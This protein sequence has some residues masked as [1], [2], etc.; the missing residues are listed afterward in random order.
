MDQ[1]FQDEIKDLRQ[2]IARRRAS[3]SLPTDASQLSAVNAAEYRV[4]TESLVPKPREVPVRTVNEATAPVVLW[5]AIVTTNERGLMVA[6][7]FNLHDDPDSTYVL[8]AELLDWQSTQP[9]RGDLA[10]A[11]FAYDQFLSKDDGDSRAKGIIARALS[12]QPGLDADMLRVRVHGAFLP[13]LAGQVTHE[14]WFFNGTEFE[15]LP[16]YGHFTI[17]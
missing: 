8:P 9:N 11:V 16:D 15:V 6:R 5:H 1:H 17:S 13:V 2:Y 4:L 7:D 3:L 14:L 10:D 12:E